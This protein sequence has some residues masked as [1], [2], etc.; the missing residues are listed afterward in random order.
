MTVKA[1]NCQALAVLIA[2]IAASGSLSALGAQQTLTRQIDP[3]TPRLMIPALRSSEKGLGQTA[4]DAIRSRV[5]QD[6]SFKALY[7]LPKNDINAT[8]AAS[9][10]PENEALAPN[11]ARELG[12]LLRADEYLTGTVSKVGGTFRIEPALVLTVDNSLTQPLPVSEGGRMDAAAAG[13][14]RSLQD[15]R[16]QLD[17]YKKCTAAAREN[18][19]A[20]AIAAARTAIAAYPRATIARTCLMTAMAQNKAPQDSVLAVAREILTVDPRSRAALRIS[21]ESYASLKDSAL[22]RHDSLAASRYDSLA[23]GAYTGLLAADP[24]NPRIVEQVVTYIA[25]G[26]HAAVAVPIIDTAVAANPGESKLLDLQ[27]RLHY[28]AK[29]YKGAIAAAQNALKVDTAYADTLYFRRLYAA[30]QSDSQATQASEIIARGAAKFPTNSDLTAIYAQDL[31]KK[32]QTQQASE[33]IRR[34]LAVNPKMPGGYAQLAQLQADMGQPD[35]ALASLRMAKAN[36][37]TANVGPYAL[38]IGNKLFKAAGGTKKPE[39]YQTALHVLQYADSVVTVPLQ[40]AQAQFLMG[41][42]QLTLGQ[43]QLQLAQSTK[44]C[45]AVTAARGYFADAQINIPKGGTFNKEAAG[46][47]MGSL[48]QLSAYPDQLEKAFKCK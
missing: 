26:G 47:A 29:D 5:S 33:V 12:R 40:K 37:D 28:A 10:F 34:A 18:K 11:D 45:P 42:V 35:S 32:G 13:V 44:S 39:D 3:N 48:M 6:F 9:G 14:S 19:F 1:R 46:Q 21:A 36:G 31:M 25:A 20:D 27:F 4:A 7:A 41:V 16:K 23:V 24:S 8:L 38:T 43:Q 2:G 30:F 15:A 17:G 22:A